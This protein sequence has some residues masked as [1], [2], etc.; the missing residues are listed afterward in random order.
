MDSR[1]GWSLEKGISM[2]LS[3]HWS[4]KMGIPWK[5]VPRASAKRITNGTLPWLFANH[6]VSVRGFATAGTGLT[7]ENG[8]RGI[9]EC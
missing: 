6:K 7:V 8:M 4:V 9:L 1:R 3:S 2:E 5:A